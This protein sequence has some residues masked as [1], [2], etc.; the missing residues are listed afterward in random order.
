MPF[1]SSKIIFLLPLLYFLFQAK[2]QGIF[3]FKGDLKGDA[4]NR[5]ANQGG[6]SHWLSVSVVACLH[7]CSFL[8]QTCRVLFGVSGIVVGSL[9]ILGNPTGLVRSIGTG[10]ADMFRLPYT[11]LTRGPGAFIGGI[12]GGMSSLLRNVSAGGEQTFE[13]CKI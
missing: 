9:E 7:V 10:V 11:G 13:N 6:W 1:A 4:L 12:S 8:H 2:S 3:S 5:N